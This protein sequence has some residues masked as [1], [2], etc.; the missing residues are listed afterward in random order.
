MK[1]NKNICPAFICFLLVA[2]CVSCRQGNN[3]DFVDYPGSV[4]LVDFLEITELP[5]VEKIREAE[6][7]L[8]VENKTEDCVVFPYDYGMRIFAQSNNV[9]E[10]IPNLGNYIVKSNIIL[11]VS[12]GEVPFVVVYLLPD[13]SELKEQPSKIRVILSAYLCY[14]GTPSDEMV[15]DYIDIELEQ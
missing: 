11:T 10:E 8:F 3:A 7:N 12:S 2:S 5:D 4:P 9:W 6:I 13:Y 1:M 15:G 14:D